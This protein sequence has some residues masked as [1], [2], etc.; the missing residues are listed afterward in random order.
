MR[1]VPLTPL[2]ARECRT[3]HGVLWAYPVISRRKHTLLQARRQKYN[4]KI[5]V[6]VADFVTI[7][8]YYSITATL[9]TRC[10]LIHT[11]LHYYLTLLRSMWHARE[12]NI[13][14][15]VLL[16]FLRSFNKINHIRE[17]SMNIV[18]LSVRESPTLREL[19]LKQILIKPIYEKWAFYIKKISQVTLTLRIVHTQSN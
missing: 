7:W 13:G 19:P 12:V 6:G 16:D 14:L 18:L 5:N 17:R 8:D 10:T 4:R 9:H 3:L 11:V 2:A 1:N 15:Y